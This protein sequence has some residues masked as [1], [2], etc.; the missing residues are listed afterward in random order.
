MYVV[1]KHERIFGKIDSL[2]RYRERKRRSLVDATL[3]TCVRPRYASDFFCGTK[4]LTTD[5]IL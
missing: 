2:D 4:L 1:L 3:P 5:F